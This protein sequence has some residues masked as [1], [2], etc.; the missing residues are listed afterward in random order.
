MNH[1]ELQE[2]VNNQLGK[3]LLTSLKA[4]RGVDAAGLSTGSM[5]LNHAL[6]G[7]PFIGYV[8]GRMAEIY[9]EESS[10]KTTLTLHAIHEAQK[11]E[12]ESGVALP[13]HFVDA[14]HSLDV[15]YAEDLGVDLDNLSIAQPDSGEDAL[16]AVLASVKA[17]YRLIVVDSVAALTPQAEIDG[18]M[19]DQH[20]GLQA[21]LMSQSMRKLRGVVKKSNAIVLF[22]NQVRMKIGGWG[23][24][25]T[26]TGG[27][28]L[29]FYAT[30]RIHVKALKG[31]VKTR[32]SVG[33]EQ[34]AY[35]GLIQ[36]K[37][38]KNKVFSPYR[39]ASFFL[40][41]GQGIDRAK[42]VVEYLDYIGAYEG[43]NLYI[44]SKEKEYTPK[45]LARVLPGDEA[46]QADVL[47]IIRRID[48]ERHANRG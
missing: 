7:R 36:C 5:R 8:Y 31:Q 1:K 45:G 43:G 29:R 18:D 4:E 16:K 41:Y 3:S 15:G 20:V 14:E 46:V 19:G 28:A 23:T 44:P 27:K 40:N 2:Q 9:G 39:E 35:G 17:G 12:R 48:E 11:L 25:E 38:T 33:D 47:E 6:S 22:T 37:V 32:K 34:E 42:D 30:Y 10:G 26:T 21:R 13:C 24:P